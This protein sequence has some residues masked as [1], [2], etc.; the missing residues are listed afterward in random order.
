MNDLQKIWLLFL[1]LNSFIFALSPA[2]LLQ[3]KLR[4]DTILQ[5]DKQKQ[6]YTKNQQ[7][8]NNTLVEADT[9]QLED[10]YALTK[11]CFMINKFIFHNTK[12][13][14]EV[15]LRPIINL[16]Q[17]RCLSQ[18][19]ISN[20]LKRIN[21]IYIEKGYIT[22]QAYLEAQDLSTKILHIHLYEGKIDY[23]VYN[24]E[25][26]TETIT[27][28][29]NIVGKTLNLRD[30]EMG[31]DQ[32][33][34]LP[35][36]QATLKLLAGQYPGYSTINIINKPQYLITGTA[37]IDTNGLDV[38]GKGVANL[39]LYV[40]NPWGYNS[41]FSINFN[42]SVNQSDEKRSR[43]SSIDW[44]IPYGY[45][46]YSLGYR[47]YLYRSTIFGTKGNYVSSG[48]STSYHANADYTFYRDASTIYKMNLALDIKE[49]LNFIANQLIK[50][51]STKLTV[52]SLGFS[53]THHLKDG[54]QIT[55]NFS[56]YQGL[57]LFDPLLNRDHLYKRAQFTKYT[58]NAS[59]TKDFTYKDIPLTL[60][61]NFLGQYSNDKLYSPEL[62]S[63]G[64]FYTVRGF[65][66]MG[67]YG[68]IGAYVH[69]D[70]IYQKSISIYGKQIQ[71]SPYVGFDM[72][73]IEYDPGIFKYM[74]GTAFGTKAT[75]GDFYVSFDIGIPLLAT[76]PIAE[77][78]FT[79]SF[80]LQYHF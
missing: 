11:N 66:Y 80:S 56:I 16:Y 23:I 2:D 57:N 20:L 35:S 21:N 62:I 36:N 69:N 76:D 55:S 15:D 12:I 48:I 71:L 78:N 64:G 73:T 59:I 14:T 30:I 34:R 47:E 31:L 53:G 50:T 44:S 77:E 72:G 41:Q 63:I 3:I 10:E 65:A 19:H 18:V 61:S 5:Q 7:V 68:E 8:Q 70:V 54:S 4:N 51:S 6:E 1:L 58:L 37:S 28:F 46:L 75:V 17:N 67:Y 25:Q 29:P 24:G 13:L 60:N 40:D 27:A 52:A 9:Y 42:G 79:T 39:Q 43:G 49:N 74:V 33:N 38:T 26:A 22:S 32:I 45:F